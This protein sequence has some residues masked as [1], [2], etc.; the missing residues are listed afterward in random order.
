M[1]TTKT[2][3]VLGAGASHTYGL[4]LGDQ[5]AAY[6]S[7]PIAKEKLPQA[8]SQICEQQ[9]VL[10]FIDLFEKSGLNSIDSFLAKQTGDREKFVEIGKHAIAYRLCSAES[11]EHVESCDRANDWYR[12]LW[13][14]MTSEISDVEE[15]LRNQVRF[16]TFNYDRSLEYYYFHKATHTFPLTPDKAVDWVRR[17]P[18]LHVYG[19]LGEF[20][21]VDTESTRSY[22]QTTSVPK[23]ALAAKSIRVIPEARGDSVEFGKAQEWLTWSE[24]ICFL[25]FGFDTLNVRRLDFA[26][27]IGRVTTSESVFGVFQPEVF[28]TTKGKTDGQIKG[29]QNRLGVEPKYWNFRDA[30]CLDALRGW[31]FLD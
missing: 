3:F 11:P 19:S 6:F 8:L 13:N 30:S 18:I 7:M 4:P 25:G 26:N 28:A 23:I 15:I 29:I 22:S 27:C 12:Y 1:I 21:S 31:G 20:D 5:L 9:D 24:R 17:L 2:V 10:K 16:I 14:A